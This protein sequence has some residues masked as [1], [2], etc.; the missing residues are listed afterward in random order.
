MLSFWDP[1]HKIGCG[2][3]DCPMCGERIAGAMDRT[4]AKVV[5]A[6]TYKYQADPPEIDPSKPVRPSRAKCRGEERAHVR[7][8]LIA[9]QRREALAILR[10]TRVRKVYQHEG[11]LHVGD[12]QWLAEVWLELENPTVRVA[13]Q[14]GRARL[15]LKERVAKA[16]NRA[17]ATLTRRR[18]ELRN[19]IN[20]DTDLFTSD[21]KF[22][23]YANTQD[24]SE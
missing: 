20:L 13:K 12:A 9:D 24:E 7:R 14:E 10:G 21:G 2:W 5:Q 8:I 6:T 19:H 16:V 15:G 22:E 18:V 3:V 4:H 11:K 1:V 17:Q 23:P